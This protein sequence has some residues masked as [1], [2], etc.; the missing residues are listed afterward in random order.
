[1]E[2]KTFSKYFVMTFHQSFKVTKLIR[3]PLFDGSKQI[4]TEHFIVTLTKVFS[5][6]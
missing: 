6:N 4:R 3:I 2:T 5:I 1:M